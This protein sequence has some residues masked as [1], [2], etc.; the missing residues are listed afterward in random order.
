[1]QFR[2]KTAYGL[3]LYICTNEPEACG[4]MT[5]EYKAGKLSII[6]CDQCRD[7]YLIVKPGGKTQYM[8]G[9]TNYKKDGSGCSRAMSPGYYYDF[10]GIKDTKPESPVVV[11]SGKD[12]KPK[13]SMTPEAQISKGSTDKVVISSAD[14]PE[15][16]YRD[17]PLNMT[18]VVILQSLSDASAYKYPSAEALIDALRGEPTKEKYLS[19]L[20]A[21]G[22]LKDINEEDLD[23]IVGW[24]ID[25]KF[26]LKTKENYPVL[27]PTYNGVHYGE[28]MKKSMLL[29]LKKR[30]EETEQR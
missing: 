8:L 19:S 14:L 23:F 27:H 29:D 26:I 16:M 28:T 2:Y 13:N 21:F 24:L 7:G 3:R 22:Q 5:N 12:I 17:I 4:F 30:L 9:C 25:K 20:D 15:I 10:M 18:L 1:M 6:K 11:P